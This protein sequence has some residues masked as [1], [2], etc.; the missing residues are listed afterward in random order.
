MPEPPVPPG[1]TTTASGLLPTDL[2][3]ADALSDLRHPTA[4]LSEWADGQRRRRRQALCEIS[5]EILL[6]LGQGRYEV[7]KNPIPAGAQII[8]ITAD[9]ET[10]RLVLEH[11]TFA[12]VRA[13]DLLPHLDPLWVR[14]LDDA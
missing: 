13:G 3:A 8:R 4:W 1:D 6:I 5:T 7:V 11:E 2:Q 14:R 9:L 10:I 12:E